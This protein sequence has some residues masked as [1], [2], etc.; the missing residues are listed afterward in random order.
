LVLEKVENPLS[1]Q[2]RNFELACSHYVL[3]ARRNTD[4]RCTRRMNMAAVLKRRLITANGQV[5]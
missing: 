2:F 3:G 4:L 5:A 1:E